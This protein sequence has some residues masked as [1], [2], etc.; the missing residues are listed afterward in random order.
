MNSP[1]RLEQDS[2]ARAAALDPGLSILLQ[3][4]AGSGKTEVLTQRFLR[5][6]AVVDEPEEILALTF[7]RKAAAEM[8]RRIL[9]ILD[10]DIDPARPT[11]ALLA[12]LRAAVL[13]RARRRDWDLLELRTRLRI[14]TIDSLNHEIA[15]SMPL[16]GKGPAGLEV[17]DHAEALYREAARATLHAAESEPDLQPAADRILR[18]LDN[19]LGRAEELLAGLFSRRAQWLPTIMAREPE[20]LAPAVEQSLH[21]IVSDVLTR[22]AALLPASLRATAEHV[23]RGAAARLDAEPGPEDAWW[24]PWLAPDAALATDASRLPEWRA[25]A[26]VLLKADGDWRLK[27]DKRQGFPTTARDAKAAAVALIQDATVIDGLKEALLS[28][29]A[30]PSPRL[31]DEEHA[32]LAALARLLKFGAQMLRVTFEVA[33]RVD[34]AEVAGVAHAGLIALGSPSDLALRRAA[35]L[36]HL[37]VDEF[38]DTSVEQLQ[39]LETLVLGWEDEGDRSMF[40]VGDPMQS[41]YQFRSAEVGL[42]LRA[43][44]H[45]VGELALTSLSLTRNFRSTHALVSW[46][47]AAFAQVFPPRDDVR[48]SAVSFHA[49]EPGLAAVDAPSG[50]GAPHVRV[51]PLAS[52]VATDEAEALAREV[53]AARARLPGCSVAVLVQAASHAPPIIE[54]LRRHGLVARG[55]ELEPLSRQ[56]AVRDIVELGCALLHPGDR[57]AW[58]TTLRAPWCGLTLADLHA[59]V[60]AAAG[61]VPLLERLGD[62]GALAALSDDARLRLA[63]CAPVLAEA[64]ELRGRGPFMP[65]L[66]T[67]WERL[68]GPAALNDELEWQQVQAWLGALAV[69]ERE[70]RLD[71]AALRELAETLRVGSEAAPEGS[72]EVLTIHRSKGLEWDVVLLPGLNRPLRGDD[73]PLLSWIELPR[74]DRSVDLL[75]AALSIGRASEDDRLA[76][77][78]A[79][80]RRQRLRHERSRLAYVAAT[81]ARR[82]LHLFGHAPPDRDGRPAPRNGSM[83]QTFWPAVATEFDA[84]AAVAPAPDEGNG[85]SEGTTVGTP[86]L[87]RLPAAWRLPAPF[88]LPAIPRLQAGAESPVALTPEFLWVGQERRA[89]GTVVHAELERMA[90]ARASVGATA[91]DDAAREPA[92]RL[93]L[94]ELGVLAEHVPAAV[95][96]IAAI[97]AGVA[98]DERARWILSPEHTEAASELRLSGIVEGE[99]RD[100]IIDRTFVDASGTRWVVDYKTGTHEG[101]DLEGFLAEELLRYRPQLELYRRLV[102]ALGPQPVRA[103]LYFPLLE[104]FAE[105][106]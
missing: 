20:A 90:A 84:V 7:T 36:K 63:R 69:R 3:A 95:R 19:N 100:V 1:L 86:P 94:L 81:R 23:L 18:R 75:M 80:L 76:Q 82:E 48:E 61:D 60:G 98:R 46:C 83:L 6:L 16:L 102:G 85:E 52:A 104:R 5:L 21:A 74:P 40:V 72:I 77:Y 53:V 32:A 93:R 68:G 57:V 67:L 12:Q 34:H 56:P 24:R 51:T 47:N 8:R 70:T 42:F 78:I 39:L 58:L 62:P 29:R 27:I 64:V 43:R 59:L 31:G 87:R 33:G 13:E 25:F 14:Q 103:A 65:A 26:N 54:A 66:R 88:A 89:I 97:L 35:A 4:P 38:Q 17:T 44:E 106:V 55:V 2:A 71:G 37:L 15:R 45:G 41:I 79:L 105:L 101:A 9:G 11:A 73:R 92:W 50:N 22:L 96:S 49:A 99:L 28:M 10:G 91:V 30:L